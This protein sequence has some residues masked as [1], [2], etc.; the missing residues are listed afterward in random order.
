MLKLRRKVGERVVII[1]PDSGPVTVTVVEVTEGTVWIGF[2][3][4]ADTAI[5]REEVLRR[6]EAAQPKPAE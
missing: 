6:I 3:A 5:H 1:P 2:Q 4:D